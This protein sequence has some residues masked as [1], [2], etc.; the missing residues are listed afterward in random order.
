MNDAE[1]K[2]GAVEIAVGDDAHETPVEDERDPQQGWTSWLYNAVTQLINPSRLLPSSKHAND[3]EQAREQ[4][5]PESVALRLIQHLITTDYED[6]VA[7]EQ[8]SALM[9]QAES[10]PS[11]H[12][13]SDGEG[14]V[15]VCVGN[16]RVRADLSG[17]T[18]AHRCTATLGELSHAF[19][20]LDQHFA[21][22]LVLCTEVEL[23]ELHGNV[24]AVRVSLPDQPWPI[25]RTPVAYESV[26]NNMLY[27][28][29]A[30]PRP[31]LDDQALC[32]A[33]LIALVFCNRRESEPTPPIDERLTELEHS[34]EKH[35]QPRHTMGLAYSKSLHLLAFQHPRLYNA[36]QNSDFTRYIVCNENGDPR[37]QC[38]RLREELQQIAENARRPLAQWTIEFDWLNSDLLNPPDARAVEFHAS[39]VVHGVACFDHKN[40]NV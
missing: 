21:D 19:A 28:V 6:K 8:L 13:M 11:F 12:A 29:T 18:A 39:F 33:A 5:P 24:H 20:D 36:I 2:P 23:T 26:Q 34:L 37:A 7:L 38:N 32:T 22:S 16:V 1:S 4:G 15:N 14:V 35:E 30:R 3:V 17:A 40:T 31:S 10:T 27:P 25:K 9:Q